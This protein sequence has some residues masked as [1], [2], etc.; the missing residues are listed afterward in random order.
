MSYTKPLAN[1]L[2]QVVAIA[3]ALG[4]AV[5]GSAQTPQYTEKVLHSFS[6]ADGANP[7]ASLVLDAAG[8]L[9]G[10]TTY[11]GAYGYGSVFE[12]SPSCSSGPPQI[13]TPSDGAAPRSVYVVLTGCGHPGDDINIFSDGSQLATGNITVESDGYWEAVV[14]P[15]Y[16]QHQLM[17]QDTSG[18]SDP[19]TVNMSYHSVTPI[20]DPSPFLYMR[21][22]DILVTS[23]AG[24]PQT[25]IY[26]ANYT[27]AALYMGGASDGT[28]LIA[29]AVTASESFGQGQVRTVALDRSTV[30]AGYPNRIA[31][32]RPIQT[33]ALTRAQRDS[34][35]SWAQ[36]TTGMGLPYWNV[37]TDMGIPIATAWLSWPPTTPRK[38]LV[39]NAMLALLTHNETSTS[40]YICSTLVWQAYLNGTGGAL[41]LS[42]PNLMS[43]APGSILA[44]YTD[45]LFMSILADH[46][47]VPETF[48]RSPKLHQIR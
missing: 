17:A 46:F 29:E 25:W 13:L 32:F 38:L 33:L 39:L 47:I 42:Q 1:I 16:G 34:I 20:K 37:P 2:W 48:V 4:V 30:Y 36:S 9:Y 15:G 10:T 31:V 44:N 11:F 18:Y 27:H 24:S 3:L 14:K 40:K 21:K 5:R 28:P 22:A 6:G 43:A 7:Y 19:V 41:D 12:L 35:V 23:S 8:N 26:G 45:P